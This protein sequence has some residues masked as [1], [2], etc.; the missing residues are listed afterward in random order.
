MCY[1]IIVDVIGFIKMLILENAFEK[2][3]LCRSLV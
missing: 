3:I 1:A 2:I